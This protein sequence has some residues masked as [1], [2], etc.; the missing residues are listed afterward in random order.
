MKHALPLVVTVAFSIVG[1]IGDY[2]LKLAS[3]QS[4]PLKSRSFYIGFVI[5][6]STA[7]GWVYAMRDL[8]LATVVR[9]V[10][11]F[12]DRPAHLHGG[13]RVPAAAC[14]PGLIGLAMAIGSLILLMRFA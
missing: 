5:Y 10:L 11:H 6:A 7:L 13:G 3:D 14:H 8:K 12:D 4:S 1:V 2:F 9:R